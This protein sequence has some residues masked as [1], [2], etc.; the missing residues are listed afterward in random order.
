MIE[1][2]ATG[3]PNPKTPTPAP[4]RQNVNTEKV[5]ADKIATSEA[6]QLEKDRA[7]ENSLFP[8]AKP[9]TAGINASL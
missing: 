6:E 9:T 7:F 5:I 2:N 4:D 8:P 3:K 1:L